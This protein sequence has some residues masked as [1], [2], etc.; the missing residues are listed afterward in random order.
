MSRCIISNS[1][2]FSDQKAAGGALNLDHGS[3]ASLVECTIFNSSASGHL[4]QGGAF[5]LIVGSVL[6]LT[7]CVVTLTSI[8]ASSAS[9]PTVCSPS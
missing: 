2:V 5:N 6:H 8:A 3:E 4:G 9:D 7:G 1:S